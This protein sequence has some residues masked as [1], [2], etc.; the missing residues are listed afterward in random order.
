MRHHNT[1]AFIA[2][3]VLASGSVAAGNVTSD[4][5]DL[6]IKTRGGLKIK[7]EDGDYVAIDGRIQLDFNGYDG[8]INKVAGETGSDIF[9]RRAR[10]R[11]V[12]QA[13]GWSY[14]VSY[15]LID[16]G[17]IDQMNVSYEAWS[18]IVE[19]TF[20]QQKENFGLE[21]TGNSKWITAIE[22]SMPANAFSIDKNIGVQ[23][24]GAND[25]ITYNVGVFKESIDAED[26]S[27]DYALTGRIVVRP[28]YTD[29][30]LVHL[31][32]GFSIRDGE[33]D[34]IGARLGVRGG[35]DKTANQIAAEYE[36]VDAIGDEL[37]LWNLEVATLFG[38]YHFMAEYFSGKLHGADASPD[39]KA[40]GYY[41]QGG[42]IVTGESRDYKTSNGS[43]GKVAANRDIG[44]W[45]VFARYDK[46]DTSDSG[47]DPL[48][49]IEGGK[50]DTVTLGVNWY[51][52]RDV[53]VAVNYVYARTDD[54]IG[55]E[56]SGNALVLRLQYLF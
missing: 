21:N 10:V 9:F 23:L 4:G 33:F 6:E 8:V 49:D 7:T 19:L 12:G 45:E 55:G 50:G 14:K 52:N 36:N 40:T 42:W 30:L 37:Q 18:D 41:L 46:L 28:A 34:S 54:E 51:A 31:G 24:H 32:A 25:M 15:N 29:D 53:K 5:R 56:D 26:N 11:I 43:F 44:A 47:T 13:K 1:A 38:P 2:A 35:E 39:I 22:R 3:A 48:L 20:G 17:S 27:L 16:G